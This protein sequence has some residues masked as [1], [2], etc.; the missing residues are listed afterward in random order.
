[1]EEKVSFTLI[2]RLIKKWKKNLLTLF[3]LFDLIFWRI[4]LKM[5]KLKELLLKELIIFGLNILKI[6]LYK[7]LGSKKID[8]NNYNF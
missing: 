7:T 4:I 8:S 2:G 1:M 3:G 6:S 5:I